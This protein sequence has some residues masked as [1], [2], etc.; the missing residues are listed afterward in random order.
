MYHTIIIAG[1]VGRD[2]KCATRP[3]ASPSPRFLS[4]PIASTPAAAAK[5]SRK[6]SGSASQPGA[7]PPKSATNTS[8]KA[9]KFWSKARCAPIR[10]PA[11]PRFIRN[12]MAHTGRV[13][14]L[15]PIQC[16][17]FPAAM[18]LAAWAAETWAAILSARPKKIFPSRYTQKMTTC[19]AASCHLFWE[20]R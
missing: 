20:M 4:Q 17:S 12:K 7:R 9:A 6:P 3:Q 11:R 2:L 18:K 1:N 10:P 19:R 5:R 13:T 15:P 14:K 16:A 8:K